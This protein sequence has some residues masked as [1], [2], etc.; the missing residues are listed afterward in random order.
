LHCGG[1]TRRRTS[2]CMRA[3]RRLTLAMSLTDSSYVVGHLLH[4]VRKA[5]SALDVRCR[6]REDVVEWSG[7]RSD[8][9]VLT[10][11]A[12]SC[13]GRLA[14][15]VTVQDDYG[16]C[17]CRAHGAS[18]CG[19]V[20]PVPLRN[21]RLRHASSPHLPPTSGRALCSMAGVYK[22]IMPSSGIR[23]RVR[24]F[25]TNPSETVRLRD[26]ENR[27]NTINHAVQVQLLKLFM[28]RSHTSVYSCKP[29]CPQRIP[30]FILMLLKFICWFGCRG[31]KQ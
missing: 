17:C 22:F 27:D 20:A 18:A 30:P 24:G 31:V 8:S 19:C 16:L 1:W 21:D 2:A 3:V 7:C 23:N 14:F 25:F 5:E 4:C 12:T 26:F 13:H 15:R 28:T 10:G 11:A 6:R 29:A 9:A